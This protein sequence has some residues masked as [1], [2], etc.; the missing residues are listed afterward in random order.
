[1]AVNS[2][3]I[4]TDCILNYIYILHIYT[5]IHFIFSIIH[6]MERTRIVKSKKQK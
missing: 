3:A 5:Q 1:M 2:K 4:Y 6:K